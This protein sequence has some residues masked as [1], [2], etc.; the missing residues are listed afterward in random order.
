MISD[1]YDV[2]YVF[3]LRVNQRRKGTPLFDNIEKTKQTV[4]IIAVNYTQTLRTSDSV[5]K[6]SM[7]SHLPYPKH[8]TRK[9]Q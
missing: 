1:L 2:S 3:I 5:R 6:E 4:N 8:S 9:S 7:C